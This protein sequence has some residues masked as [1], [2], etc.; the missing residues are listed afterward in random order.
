[1][2]GLAAL[3]LWLAQVGPVVPL[4]DPTPARPPDAVAEAPRPTPA[5]EGTQAP[6]PSG[7]RPAPPALAEMQRDPDYRYDRPVA[8]Q[9][10]A[11]ERLMAWIGEH[12]LAPFFRFSTTR[13]GQG[14]WLVVAALV[15]LAVALRVT[16]TGLGGLFTRR[17][18]ALTDGADPL[19]GVDDIATVDLP[20]LLA[21]AVAQREWRAAVRLRYLVALQRLDAADLVAWAPDKTNQTFVREATARGGAD[22]G[23]AFS[24]VTRAFET[25]WYGGI[26]VDAA[27]WTRVGTRFERLDAA[28]AA[29]PRSGARRPLTTEP[30]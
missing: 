4:P 28:L 13:G 29:L 25:V 30:A 26:S 19:V 6:S 7:P 8:E 14:F 27:R 17:G 12:L 24:D 22:L 2:S 10:S 11:L 23:R 20:A 9:P 5:S 16:Q 15:L 18:L 21:A 3:V 1:M